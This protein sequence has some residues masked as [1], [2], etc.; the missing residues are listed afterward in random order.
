MREKKNNKV[1][2]KFELLEIKYKHWCGDQRRY[3]FDEQQSLH[4]CFLL[5]LNGFC[6]NADARFSRTHSLLAVL[7]QQSSLVKV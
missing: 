2:A 5:K 4:C 1:Q 6:I 3:D 7:L